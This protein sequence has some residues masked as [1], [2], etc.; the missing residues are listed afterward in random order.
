MLGTNEE[1][2]TKWREYYSLGK[3]ITYEIS[4]YIPKSLI[5]IKIIENKKASGGVWIYKFSSYQERGVLQIKRLA[6]VQNKIERFTRRWIDT[7]YNE[8]DYQLMT[9]NSY[10][11]QLM[12]DQ[13]EVMEILMP[14]SVENNESAEIK[15]ALL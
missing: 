14:D 6:V 7:K 3:S 12:E 8:V 9:L 1:G 15:E 2:L 10:L 5:E 4:E 11:N 13:D